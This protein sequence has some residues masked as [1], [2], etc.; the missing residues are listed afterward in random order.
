MWDKRPA[1]RDAM[2]LRPCSSL[3]G[4]GQASRL[5]HVPFS[6]DERQVVQIPAFG[7]DKSVRP[8]RLA[9]GVLRMSSMRARAARLL[10][11]NPPAYS[12]IQHVE[13]HRSAVQD[14]VMKSTD[15]VLT[16]QLL[17]RTFP[18]L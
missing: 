6:S 12:L 9:I 15:V 2:K 8:T 18:K 3:V 13:R 11:L 1:C 4:S 5:S 14:F 16:A 10:R 7:R 17:L